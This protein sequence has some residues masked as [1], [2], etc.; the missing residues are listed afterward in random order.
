MATKMFLPGIDISRSLWFQRSPVGFVRL[1][2]A[3]FWAAWATE[4][5]NNF[6]Q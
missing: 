1:G 5:L 2:W 6:F 3:G 4:I